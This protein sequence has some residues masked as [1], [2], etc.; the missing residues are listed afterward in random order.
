[1]GKE[2][3]RVTAPANQ[4][5]AVRA[6]CHVRDFFKT[7]WQ[8]TSLFVLAVVVFSAAIAFLNYRLQLKSSEPQLASAG[9]GLGLKGH[10]ISVSLNFRNIGKRP[11][12][13]GTVTLFS[14]NEAHTRG[15]KL[16]EE[17]MLVAG[18][19]NVLLPGYDANATFKF[20]GE[21]PELFLACLIYFDDKTRLQQAFVY[22]IE[23]R[24]ISVGILNEIEQPDYGEVCN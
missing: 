2:V 19:L 16:G 22:R 14:F 11:A 24:D 23:R 1:V 7:Q 12:R 5:V 21:V 20:E 6:F 10:P 18:G 9:A 17:K 15:Q 13:E 8:R 3:P 4:N